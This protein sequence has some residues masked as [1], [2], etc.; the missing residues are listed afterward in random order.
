MGAQDHLDL[1][2][3][4][5]C[6]PTQLVLAN[7]VSCPRQQSGVSPRP[8]GQ[9]KSNL[10][11]CNPQL[12][13]IP[14]NELNRRAEIKLDP[15]YSI[16]KYVLSSQGMLQQAKTYA[17]EGNLNNAYILYLRY[18]TLLL[19]ELPQHPDYKKERSKKYLSHMKKCCRVALDKLE[20]MKAQLESRYTLA[21]R[22][23]VKAESRQE[24]S[25]KEYGSIE[26]TPSVSTVPSS[27]IAPSLPPPPPLPPA[28]PAPMGSTPSEGGL[29]EALDSL[30]FSTT[31]LQNS[32]R[33]SGATFKDSQSSLHHYPDLAQSH[34]P[35][36]YATYYQPHEGTS[37]NV[38]Q[39]HVVAARPTVNQPVAPPTIPHRA[40]FEE[41]S[42]VGTASVSS[43]YPA[44]PQSPPSVSQPSY[45]VISPD[46]SQASLRTPSQSG[47]YKVPPQGPFQTEYTMNHPDYH[48]RLRQLY[49]PATNQKPGFFYQTSMEYDYQRPAPHVP[50]KPSGMAYESPR[51]YYASSEHLGT[52]HS[53]PREPVLPPKPLGIEYRRP[54]SAS[55]VSPAETSNS[56]SKL[57]PQRSA[58]GNSRLGYS[59][60]VSSRATAE[61]GEPLRRIHVPFDLLG[62][63]LSKARKNTDRNL[64]TCGV[65]CGYLRH[66]EFYLTTLLIPKQ[67][68]T[69]DTC[70][71]TNEEEIV[72][73]QIE[74][75]LITLGW[76]HTHPTQT[77]FMSSL[78][79]HTH[80]SYQQMLPEA[81]AIVCAPQHSPSYGIFRLTDPPGMKVINM[82]RDKRPFHP[83]ENTNIYTKAAEPDHVSVEHFDFT[84][85]DMR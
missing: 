50:P 19:R 79:I 74:K 72:E 22:A 66:D 45:T 68:A 33:H 17:E 23:A 3:R 52:T 58:Q 80:F 73:Y 76:I 20:P 36:P 24:A 7:L 83:H 47:S 55:V 44:F 85:V 53:S 34:S 54:S 62:K 67:T 29:S 71:T 30:K 4:V 56:F 6:G 26:A 75:D 38:V 10:F 9:S 43:S 31:H 61:S 63:F 13:Y 49:A 70:T 27:T 59:G 64:E 35:R 2:D 78:D 28:R 60:P 25:T 84:M 1:S 15:R 46:A 69:S 11:Y 42:S 5:I 21:K 16:S 32:Q 12:E 65:L 40:Q 41:S 48:A 51:G 77:C 18:T 57:H 39:P 37:V 8:D 81:I 14:I 82:C